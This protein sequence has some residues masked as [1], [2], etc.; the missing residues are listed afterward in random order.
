MAELGWSASEATQENLQN[1]LNQGY[2]TAVELT[3]CRVP[4][5]PASPVPTGG[6]GYVIAYMAFYELGTSSLDPIRDLTFGSLL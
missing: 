4:E 5:D 2:M 1:L 6:G 3:T